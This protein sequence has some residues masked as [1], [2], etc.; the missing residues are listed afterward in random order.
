MKFIKKYKIPLIV[1]V[2]CL[3]LITLASFAIYR[4]FYPNSGIDKYGSRLDGQ[5]AIDDIA[6]QKIEDEITAL[7]I[8]NKIEYRS[9][10]ANI[11]FNIEVIEG[12]T[13][14]AIR[15]IFPII[16]NNLSTDVLAFYDIEVFI[17][18]TGNVELPMIAYKSKAA[19]EFSLTINKE[20]SEV[21]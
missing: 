15:G 14:D 18:G 6:I 9:N 13:T 7:A 4:M 16:I 11:K 2:V 8:T 21:E 3:V 12:T 17:T 5:I 10:G 1:G 19:T 20:S